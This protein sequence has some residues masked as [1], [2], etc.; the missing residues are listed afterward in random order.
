MDNAIDE[1]CAGKPAIVLSDRPMNAR[2]RALC[3]EGAVSV[4]EVPALQRPSVFVVNAANDWVGALGQEALVAIFT[5]RKGHLTRWRELDDRYPDAPVKLYTPYPGDASMSALADL[6]RVDVTGAIGTKLGD[7]RTIAEA[8]AFDRNGLG[9][10][11]GDLARSSRLRRIVVTGRDG[12]ALEAGLAKALIL[13][14]N[15]GGVRDTA[16]APVAARILQTVADLGPVIGAD[17]IAGELRSEGLARLAQGR[18]G[19][20]SAPDWTGADMLRASA[21]KYRD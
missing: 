19:Y 2:E 10:V 14:V 4:L 7:V 8:I 17:T 3:K 11:P 13:Y 15:A 1:L 16:Y 12:T 20:V 18:G 5:A 9:W 6:L 21:L